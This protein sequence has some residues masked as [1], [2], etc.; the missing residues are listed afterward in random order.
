[1]MYILANP[2]WNNTPMSTK[3]LAAIA[4][5]HNVP[6]FVDAAATELDLPNPHIEA[7][8]DLVAY[9]GGKCMRGPQSSGLLIGKKNLC[10]ASYFAGR[11]AP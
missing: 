4:K 10:Q 6:V 2:R 11:S 1:M 9:S 7:G 8:A 3:N 5:E